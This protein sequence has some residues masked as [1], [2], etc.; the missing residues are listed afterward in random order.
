MGNF[1]INC[2]RESRRIS[3][4]IVD[5]GKVDQVIVK[6]TRKKINPSGVFLISLNFGEDLATAKSDFGEQIDKQ[7]KQLITELADVTDEPQGLPP[8]RGHLDHKVKRTGYPPRHRRNRLSV[9]EYEELKHQC[10]ELFKEGKVRISSGPY[11]APIVM[12]R[13]SDSL[14]RLCIDYRPINECTVK[15]SFPHPHV[16]DLIDKL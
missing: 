2:N 9:P 1:T 12:V 4:M 6:H 14:I 5:S 11:V 15:D 7:L 8:H 13:K 3:C 16:D 10:I